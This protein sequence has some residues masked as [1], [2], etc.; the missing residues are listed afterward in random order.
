MRTWQIRSNVNED[1]VEKERRRP[2]ALQQHLKKPP[3]DR[4]TCEGLADT[5]RN[6][7]VLAARRGGA[8]T[9]AG[10]GAQACGVGSGLADER[11]LDDLAVA[12]L[13]LEAAAVN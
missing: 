9:A 8:G 2:N 10:R 13:G 11:S 1:K 5:I 12:L 4:E 3:D 6:R 7:C